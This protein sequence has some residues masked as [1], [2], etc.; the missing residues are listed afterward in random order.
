MCDSFNWPAT[1]HV[2]N[3]E[4]KLYLYDES[5][6]LNSLVKFPLVKELFLCVCVG[7]GGFNSV[8]TSSAPTS[9]ATSLRS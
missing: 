8:I 1:R 3:Q 9:G 4:L 5:K 6:Q 7:G 2:V